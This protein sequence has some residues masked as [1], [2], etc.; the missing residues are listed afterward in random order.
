MGF[1]WSIQLPFIEVLA[2]EKIKK[3]NYGKA[4]LFGS[5]GFTIVALWIGAMPFDSHFSMNIYVGTITLT[6]LFGLLLSK[7]ITTTVKIIT[8]SE[9]Q[10]RFKHIELWI[11]LF[12]VQVGFGGFY[13]F[14]TIFEGEHG[15]SLDVITYLWAFG[16]IA[17]IVMFMFQTK[18]LHL[19]LLTLMKLSI[20]LTAI[21]W[22]M[23]SLYPENIMILYASQSLHAFSLALLHTVSITYI[24]SLYKENQKLAQQFYLGITFGLG[25]FIGSLL[26]GAVYGEHIFTVM[27]LVTLLALYFIHL[28]QK[29]Q[30]VII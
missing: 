10:N 25:M 7:N 27:S 4:R 11:G 30:L 3:E 21:R 15:I 29:R 26:S 5:I 2:L 24:F 18:F 17:E 23:V 20:F 6:L 12:L 22:L 8:K 9:K 28:H 16:V 14:F 13:N 1:F 19:P